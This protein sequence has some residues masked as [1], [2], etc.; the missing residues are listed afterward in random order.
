MVPLVATIISYTRGLFLGSHFPASL[1]RSTPGHWRGEGGTQLNPNLQPSVKRLEWG[2]APLK[3]PRLWFSTR[4]GWLSLCRLVRGSAVMLSVYWTVMA[5]KQVCRRAKLTG[6]RWVYAP[7]L[8]YGHELWVVSE[9][10]RSWIQAVEMSFLWRV[11]GCSLEVEKLSH[12]GGAW[13]RV[14]A[15]SHAGVSHGQLDTQMPVDA[16]LGGEATPRKTQNTGETVFLS[17]PENT[18]TRE[19]WT[20]GL[21]LLPPQPQEEETKQR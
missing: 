17:W 6:Y 8:T 5:K 20:S 4:K 10:T 15:P 2:S 19:V 1:M 7:S 16:S 21:R 13:S 14:A 12:S 9:R 3:A 18:G 11:A